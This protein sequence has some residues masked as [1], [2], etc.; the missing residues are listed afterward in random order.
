[1]EFVMNSVVDYLV[2]S[3]VEFAMDHEMEVCLESLSDSGLGSVGDSG[4]RILESILRWILRWIWERVL[5]WVMGMDSAV[6][7]ETDR[8]TSGLLLGRPRHRAMRRLK[9]H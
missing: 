2:N 3:A 8:T 1:M 4:D 5:A 9:K 6:A 7:P